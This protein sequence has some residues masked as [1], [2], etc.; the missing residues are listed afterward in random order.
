MLP[1]VVG[2]VGFEAAIDQALRLGR[3]PVLLIGAALALAAIYRFG[4]DRQHA[5]W[6]WITWGSA[7]AAL[8]WLAASSLFSWY[9]AGP[10]RYRAGHARAAANRRCGRAHGS[11]QPAGQDKKTP[12][13]SADARQARADRSVS[14]GEGVFM[15]TSNFRSGRSWP[16]PCGRSAY[17]RPWSRPAFAVATSRRGRTAAGRKRKPM[18]PS[19]AGSM[20]CS[21]CMRAKAPVQGT[22]REKADTALARPTRLTSSGSRSRPRATAST[23]LRSRTRSAK[24]NRTAAYA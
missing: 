6:R 22:E 10:E 21:A 18:R 2:Y 19:A 14:P 1:I 12:S 5:K 15:E 3:W 17:R 4:P 23:A 13:G 16:H 11:G 9:A 20:C 7:T 8:L 24:P